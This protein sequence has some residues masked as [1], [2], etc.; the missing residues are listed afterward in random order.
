[1]IWEISLDNNHRK[2]H[3]PLC[4]Y[5]CYQSN[6]KF[7]HPVGVILIPNP[8]DAFAILLIPS[9]NERSSTLRVSRSEKK[10]RFA[11]GV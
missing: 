9:D 5:L 7:D 2:H 11:S 3:Q 1:M 10:L 4:L 6:A 8:N